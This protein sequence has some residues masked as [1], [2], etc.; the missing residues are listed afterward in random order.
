MNNS[1][2]VTGGA[3][4]IGSN[5]CDY[6][7]KNNNKIIIVDNFNDFYNPLIKR[8]NI[9]K[10]QNL[11]KINNI[12]DDNLIIK[13]GDIRDTIF[14]T[15]IFSLY[16]IDIVIH[17][18]AMAGVRPSIINPF[19][20]NEVNM[21]G[22]LNLLDLCNKY[23]INKFIFASSSSVY[24]NNEKLPFTESDSVDSP[25]SPYG[26]TKKSGELLCHVYSHLYGF[27]IACLRFFTVYGPRQ[28]PDL[29]IY[30]F[31]ESILKG[32][33]ISIF[34]DGTTKR[35]YTY[36]DD[37]VQG[38]D[39]A[40]TW[41]IKGNNK[42]EIFN[43]GDSTTIMLKYMIERIEIELGTKAIIKYLPMQPGDVNITYAN[44]S[45]SKEILGYNP[46]TNFDYG[47]HKFVKWFKTIPLY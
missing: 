37:I 5:L 27:N 45:K 6:L 14:L 30:K 42:Y 3:G 8:N 28:R 41:T 46:I 11:M 29:A 20:Y 34:G 33:E 44:I 1:I 9:T 19:L 16:K 4:F 12:T 26:A 43:L 40:I 25:I 7:L 21:A 47:I 2:L 15:K 22:T 38:I 35:D 23:K 17:L 32:N 13:E 24:G 31:T 18:A 10:I 39:K 36:I